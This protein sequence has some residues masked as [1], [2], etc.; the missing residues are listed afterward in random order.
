MYGLHT[1]WGGE[2]VDYIHPYGFSIWCVFA[3]KI[4]H[5]PDLSTSENVGDPRVTILVV[6][7]FSIYCVF[8]LRIWVLHMIVRTLSVSPVGYAGVCGLMDPWHALQSGHQYHP[9]S[10]QCCR[11]KPEGSICL[12][13]KWAETAFWICRAKC[14]SR[15]GRG[16]P[17]CQAGY[18]CPIHE[19][20]TN[21]VQ[22]KIQPL[23]SP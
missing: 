20:R 1:Y 8:Y 11:A 2:T 23:T 12:L 6:R 3:V 5:N 10:I 7:S 22:K 21:V 18:S 19:S 15:A 14:F 17:L 16:V 13:W 4:D 9:M